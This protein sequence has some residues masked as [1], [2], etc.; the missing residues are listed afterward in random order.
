MG[1]KGV[2]FLKETSGAGWA[3]QVLFDDQ[4]YI[5]A[6]P[7]L[8]VFLVARDELIGGQMGIVAKGHNV[9]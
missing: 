2:S 7:Q 8:N 5:Y 1:N 6:I 3:I 4:R 9:I